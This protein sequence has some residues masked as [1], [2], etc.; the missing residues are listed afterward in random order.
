[1]GDIDTLVKSF[2]NINENIVS[3]IRT[4]HLGDMTQPYV[5]QGHGDDAHKTVGEYVCTKR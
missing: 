3:I 5:W 4:R 2:R 1:M